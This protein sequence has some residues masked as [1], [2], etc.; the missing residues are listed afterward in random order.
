MSDKQVRRQF[1]P[2]EKVAIVKGH[3]LEGAAI[4]NLCDEIQINPT[5][6]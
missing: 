3:L 6:F 5:Q 4:S 1:S 2:Q